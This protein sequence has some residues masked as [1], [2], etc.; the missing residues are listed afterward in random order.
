MHVYKQKL[1][2]IKKYLNNYAKS[3]DNKCF[4]SYNLININE[5]SGGV[6]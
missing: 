6:L 5:D 1:N 2:I 3:V 4:S